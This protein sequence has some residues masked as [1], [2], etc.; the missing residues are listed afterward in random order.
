MKNKLAM[1]TLALAAV[2]SMVASGVPIAAPITVQAKTT[3][4]T[5][6]QPL[7]T[8]RIQELIITY[9]GEDLVEKGL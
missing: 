1:K 2:T 9:F 5:N 8:G 4:E 7:D 6:E 3:Y